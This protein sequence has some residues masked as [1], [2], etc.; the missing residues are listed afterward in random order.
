MMSEDFSH[1]E[2]LQEQAREAA[3]TTP[4]FDRYTG[5]DPEQ[6]AEYA[7]PPP[8]RV[9]A[10]DRGKTLHQIHQEIAALTKTPEFRHSWAGQPGAHQ[11]AHTRWR[12]LVDAQL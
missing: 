9:V 1:G 7:P 12:E 5:D 4:V 6:A 10:Q 8:E 11:A 3:R 2:F